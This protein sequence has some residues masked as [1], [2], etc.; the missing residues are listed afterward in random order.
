MDSEQQEPLLKVLIRST[1]SALAACLVLLGIV[2]KIMSFS[3]MPFYLAIGCISFYIMMFFLLIFR[4]STKEA[5]VKPLHWFFA[6]SGTVL[7][8]AIM[9]STHRLQWLTWLSLPI[10]LL[11]IIF[12]LIAIYTLGR[13]FG[14]I[15]AN[16][17]IKTSGVYKIIRHP[18]YAG[19]SLWFL[20]LVLQHI[21]VFNVALYLVQ[22]A[23][24]IRRLLEEE[25]LLQKDEKYAQYMKEV[26]WR[27][28]PGIF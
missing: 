9:T 20:S 5:S 6:I 26:P 18:L 13:S 19:E 1:V 7:P 27:V 17:E 16:R 2:I 8:L 25:T 21:S 14:I 22:S 15:A 11:G 28:I 12:S 3:K 23:C 10:E 24:Q 4:H